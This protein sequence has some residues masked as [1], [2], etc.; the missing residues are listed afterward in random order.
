MDRTTISNGELY[1]RFMLRAYC[2]SQSNPVVGADR[3][4]YYLLYMI[5]NG[6]DLRETGY[7]NQLTTL[8]TYIANGIH[9]L[10]DGE[11]HGHEREG[12]NKAFIELGHAD[13]EEAL[14]K[15][16]AK[17]IRITQRLERA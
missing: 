15:L 16:V 12:L 5:R 14:A 8:R 11:L 7:A 4:H 9:Q 10:L 1:E 2:L 13:N 3:R 17:L 6:V